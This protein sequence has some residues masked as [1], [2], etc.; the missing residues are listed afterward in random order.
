M[1]LPHQKKQRQNRRRSLLRKNKKGIERRQQQQ[2]TQTHS[3]TLTGIA[4]R[5]LIPFVVTHHA[6]HQTL[7]CFK[8]IIL[9]FFNDSFIFIILELPSIKIINKEKN[10]E[11]KSDHSVFGG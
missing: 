1:A 5:I 9:N 10:E 8:L 6:M 3:Q 4:A 11:D 7:V 2:P